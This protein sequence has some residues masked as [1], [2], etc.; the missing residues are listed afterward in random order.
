MW[1]VND[2]GGLL[3]VDDNSDNNKD[4]VCELLI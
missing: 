3:Q 1:W 4:K 2:D